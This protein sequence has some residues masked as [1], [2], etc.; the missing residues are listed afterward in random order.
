MGIP[1]DVATQDL[2]DRA[3]RAIDQSIKLRHE[4]AAFMQKA[5]RSG[6][7]IELRVYQARAA[8]LSRRPK[9]AFHSE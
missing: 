1:F 6:F 7:A 5:R 3:Q 4:R 8:L 9:P 2:L